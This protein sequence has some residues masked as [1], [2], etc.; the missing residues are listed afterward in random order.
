MLASVTTPVHVTFQL[1][2]LL[3]EGH[4]RDK[5]NSPPRGLQLQLTRNGIEVSDTLVMANVGY[6]QF[7][8]TPGVYDL[9]IRPGR[10]Q[11][12]F[13]MESTG[14]TGWSSA[15][16]NVT[17]LGVSLTSFD[18]M[19]ILPRF[20]RRAGMETADVLQEAPVS[21]TADYAGAIWSKCV[22]IYLPWS[23]TDMARM[24]QMVGLDSMPALAVAKPKHADINIFTV[25]S[26][27]LYEVCGTPKCMRTMC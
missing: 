12:V 5:L 17:G 26:G 22:T 6:L 25:A 27:L 3:I 14:T 1:K 2:Q 8:A 20:V 24:K 4:A 19:T 16:V 21:V 15:P 23:L 9:S 13:E 10:G 18:G 11:E 7:K